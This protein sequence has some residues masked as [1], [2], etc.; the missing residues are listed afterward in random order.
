MKT[1]KLLSRSFWLIMLIHLVVFTAIGVFTTKGWRLLVIFL[2]GL[3][4]IL[5]FL[6]L[7]RLYSRNYA[8]KQRLATFLSEIF[9]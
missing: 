1:K 7:L 2:S 4:A 9:N 8:G 6:W 5:F 3:L